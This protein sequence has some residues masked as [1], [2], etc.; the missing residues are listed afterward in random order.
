MVTSP[1]VFQVDPK[2]PDPAVIAEVADALRKGKLVIFP[3]E[4]VYG[5]GAS[6][7]DIDAVERLYQI[8]GRPSDRPLTAHFADPTSVHQMAVDWPV[9][10][11]K[12]AR[13]FWPGPLTLVVGRLE[14]GS[15]GLRVPRH[16]VAQALLT[17]ANIPVVAPSANATGGQPPRT[18]QEAIDQLGMHIDYV[19]D[20]GPAEY[21]V[22]STV[23]DCT[24]QPPKLLRRGA[25]YRE[26]ETMLSAVQAGG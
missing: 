25:L 24:A 16:P 3:T 18:A 21:G 17:A 14:G 10:A 22:P 13:H 1:K 4:T 6:A 9:S 8:K 5:L 11:Q 7:E 2:Q 15:V 19:V 20:A 23:V 26:I 12:L